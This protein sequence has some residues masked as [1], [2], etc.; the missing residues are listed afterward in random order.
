MDKK[1]FFLAVK[2]IIDKSDPSRLLQY[3]EDEYFG[4]AAMICDSIYRKN[5]NEKEITEVILDTF[6]YMFGDKSYCSKKDAEKM[7]KEIREKL[8]E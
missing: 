7:A 2:N 3:S 4:E 8:F 1:E 5:L 6:Y